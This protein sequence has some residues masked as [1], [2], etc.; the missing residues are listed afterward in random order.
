MKLVKLIWT[1]WNSITKG[2]VICQF[3]IQEAG[4]VLSHLQQFKTPLFLAAI[5]N[6]YDLAKILFTSSSLLTIGLHELQEIMIQEHF[7]NKLCLISLF[8]PGWL[9]HILWKVYNGCHTFF[10]KK[11]SQEELIEGAM[12]QNQLQ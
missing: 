1:S 12:L 8:Q 5:L 9:V 10:S 6:T 3:Q 2:Q 4:T 11:I 7:Q